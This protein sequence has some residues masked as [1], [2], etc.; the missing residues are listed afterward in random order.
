MVSLNRHLF[1]KWSR[2]SIIKLVDR[3]RQLLLLQKTCPLGIVVS[4]RDTPVSSWHPFTCINIFQRSMKET[5]LPNLTRYHHCCSTNKSELRR[6]MHASLVTTDDEVM[7]YCTAIDLKNEGKSP[8]TSIHRRRCRSSW[9]WKLWSSSSVYCFS[10]LM[11]FFPVEKIFIRLLVFRNWCT[12]NHLHHML[13][14]GARQYEAWGP[15]SSISL[16]EC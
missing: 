6:G 16:N 9:R 8:E 14:G 12:V 2:P 7:N 4:L 3:I 1:T 10:Q 11:F 13:D 5:V 15:V